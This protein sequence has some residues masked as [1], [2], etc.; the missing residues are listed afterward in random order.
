MAEYKVKLVMN[1]EYTIDA[2]SKEEV[3]QKAREKYGG[4]MKEIRIYTIENQSKI[5]FSLIKKDSKCYNVK[6]LDEKLIEELFAYT[7][8]PEEKRIL[9]ICDFGILV[10]VRYIK[11]DKYCMTIYYHPKD[12]NVEHYN[13]SNYVALESDY[14]LADKI[15]KWINEKAS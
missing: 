14:T 6:I 12:G 10:S 13:I 2:E 3:E 1:E 4:Y 5:Y 15:I 9:D 8:I 7:S 11:D